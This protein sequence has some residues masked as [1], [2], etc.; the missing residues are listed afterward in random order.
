M[1]A[2]F[3]R[4]RE[5]AAMLFGKIISAAVFF[6]NFNYLITGICFFSFQSSQAISFTG[7]LLE[8]KINFALRYIAICPSET[9]IPSVT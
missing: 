1:P 2:C 5:V 3:Y 4:K 8:Y 7:A 6:S 9:P